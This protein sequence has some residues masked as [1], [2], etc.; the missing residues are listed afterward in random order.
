MT[1]EQIKSQ[2]ICMIQMM[3]AKD[4]AAI[5]KY[6]VYD[7]P[8]MIRAMNQH[9]KVVERLLNELEQYTKVNPN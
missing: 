9:M 7:L 1:D 5:H 2:L 8:I 3:P 6:L 4:A